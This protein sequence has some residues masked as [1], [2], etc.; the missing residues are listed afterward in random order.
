MA[1]YLKYNADLAKRVQQVFDLMD[2]LGVE[3]NYLAGEFRISD[4]H[5]PE[6]GMLQNM[7]LMDCEGQP[8]Y[9]LPASV[10]W[11]LKVFNS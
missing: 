10:E 1:Q 3:I 2:E 8:I 11:R 7:P 6:N 4:N 5:N 9:S